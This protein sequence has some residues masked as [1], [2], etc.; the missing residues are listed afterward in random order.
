MPKY[1]STEQTHIG[2]DDEETAKDRL[3]KAEK[4]A[5]ALGWRIKYGAVF[6]DRINE[7]WGHTVVAE[8]EHKEG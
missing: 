1:A 8:T 3:A 5:T 7:I 2:W 4:E 6:Y